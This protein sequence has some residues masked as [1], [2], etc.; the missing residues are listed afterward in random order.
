MVT[1]RAFLITSTVSVALFA[2][3]PKA[4]AQGGGAAEATSFMVN[5]GNQL[6]AVVNGSGSIEQRRE[7]MQPLIERAVAVDEIGQFVLGRYWRIASAEQRQ[8]FLQLFH[9]VLIN[10]VG[11]K[12]G[13]FQG[14]TFRPTTTTPREGEYYVGTIIVRPN[15]QPNNVQW[16][17]SMAGGRP[18]IV[19]VIAEG[20]SLRLTQRS[21]YASYLARNGNNVDA[22]LTAMQRQVAA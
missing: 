10:N 6:V 20:T 2:A 19:D 7:R 3:G 21:D 14:V 18:Q 9:A 12:L 4:W 22:L 8:R 1:R 15:Q 5:F 16:V 11:S 17:V 13:E